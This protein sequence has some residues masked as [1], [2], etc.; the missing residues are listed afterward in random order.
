MSETQ[1][2][3]RRP[4]RPVWTAFTRLPLKLSQRLEFNGFFDRYWPQDG[5]TLVP[6]DASDFSENERFRALFVRYGIIQRHDWERAA[7]ALGLSWRHFKR[8]LKGEIEVPAKHKRALAHAAGVDL[9]WLLTG[10]GG[11]RP[12][13]ELP[14][15][16]VIRYTSIPTGVGPRR[17]KPIPSSAAVRGD[18]AIVALPLIQW[19]VSAGGGSGAFEDAAD[20]LRFPL[21]ILEAVPL[22]PRHACLVQVDG[23]SM[24]P[25][26]YDG[27]LLLLDISIGARTEIVDRAVYAFVR[28]H[29]A[30]VKRLQRVHERLLMVSDNL[31]YAPEQ[32]LPGPDLV[33]IIGRVRWAGVI[34]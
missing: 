28:G 8:Y 9:N 16:R 24:E 33:T 13:E 5:S 22:E 11:P 18:A 10:Q 30:Y 15:G 25:S 31:D 23:V 32:L 2:T 7:S 34:L 27:Q 26:L 17:G 19:K 14:E 29:D 1:D 21:Q 4:G 20:N 3:K 6:P 12:D